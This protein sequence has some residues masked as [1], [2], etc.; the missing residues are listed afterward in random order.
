VGDDSQQKLA[1]AVGSVRELVA[2][3]LRDFGVDRLVA[4]SPDSIHI[5]GP[6][7]LHE[8]SWN[9]TAV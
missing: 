2:R 4:T 9:P 5:L 7:G 3:V 6:A 1:D 8:Q